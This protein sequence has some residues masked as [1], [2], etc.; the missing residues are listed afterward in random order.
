MQMQVSLICYVFKQEKAEEISQYCGGGG[1][2]LLTPR[3]H[4]SFPP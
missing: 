2:S 1:K 3:P 4:L